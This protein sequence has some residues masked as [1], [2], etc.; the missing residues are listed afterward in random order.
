M[1]MRHQSITPY[2]GTETS[3]KRNP[4]EPKVPVKFKMAYVP[5]NGIPDPLKQSLTSPPREFV[6]TQ[7]FL[8]RK[9]QAGGH[10]YT[11]HWAPLR[12]AK[13][14]ESKATGM[15]SHNSRP[16]ENPLGSNSNRRGDNPLGHAMNKVGTNAIGRNSG[17]KGSN[18]IGSNSNRMG[19]KSGYPAFRPRGG[20]KNV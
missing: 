10:H 8:K 14:H 20:G 2:Q 9:V 5:R 17:R 15:G 12:E 1:G 13:G 6:D 7:H 18:A 16:G 19:E 11:P 3:T 4:A